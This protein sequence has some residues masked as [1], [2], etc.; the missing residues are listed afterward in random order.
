MTAGGN[1]ARGLQASKM[2]IVGSHVFFIQAASKMIIDAH[3]HFWDLAVPFDHGW[4]TE[5]QHKPIFKNYLP[6]DLEPVLKKAGV[7]RCVFVQTQHDIAE[8]RWA[9]R[10]AEQND[11]MA[12]VVG[13]VDLAGDVCESQLIEFKSHPK[14]L[15]VR[16]ITQSEPDDNFIVR[17]DVLAGLKVLE[18]H[19]VPFDLLFLTKHL[20]Q[21]VAV[22]RQVPDLPLVI[23]HLAKP[24]IKSG[25]ID[26]WA[27]DLRAAA[28]CENV[29][30]KLSGMVTEADWSNWSAQDLKPYV[31][32]ALEA[33]GP[34]RCMYG[35]DWPVCELAASYEQVFASI[36]EAIGPISSTEKS[37]IFGRTAAKFYGIEW[38]Q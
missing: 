16:H 6:A 37:A 27:A 9:L 19:R 11:F 21:A 18:Q 30:C 36:Q 29:Y 34:D 17:P 26:A 33:F 14:F 10:L 31:E 32:V 7:D 2:V 3:Q 8:N 12:G 38:T 13:W 1:F 22:A 15:G 4:L 24:K 5:P 35:S 20:K 25:Q 28:D 23:D